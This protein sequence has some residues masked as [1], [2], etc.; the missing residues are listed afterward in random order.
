MV[1]FVYERIIAGVDL[2]VGLGEW[3]LVRD[4]IGSWTKTKQK[5]SKCCKP[6]EGRCRTV[7]LQ[8]W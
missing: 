1:R 3:Y 5:Q 4:G 7:R 8:W 2:S 6:V